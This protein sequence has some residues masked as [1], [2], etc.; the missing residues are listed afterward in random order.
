VRGRPSHFAGL[1]VPFAERA[2]RFAEGIEIV[3]RALSTPRFTHHGGVDGVT[4][5]AVVPRPVQQPRPPIRL[6]A[7]S[8]DTC[9][10]AGRPGLPI[11]VATHVNPIPALVELVAAYRRTRRDAGHP[12]TADDVTVLAPTFTAP[13]MAE[14][15]RD[16]QPGLTRIAALA[17]RRIDTALGAVPT[18]FSR[19]VM[20]TFV[21]GALTA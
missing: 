3:E 6:A 18:L 21:D 4:D 1:G 15:R 8:A 13:T 19:A 2:A 7:K 5:V 12:D 10:L 14:L 9:E 11:I 16:V 20:P 17:T